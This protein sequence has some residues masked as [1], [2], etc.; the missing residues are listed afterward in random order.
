[1]KGFRTS[2]EFD[3]VQLL[4]SVAGAVEDCA[5]TVGDAHARGQ[6]VIFRMVS[7]GPSPAFFF[8]AIFPD[9][10]RFLDADISLRRHPR[11]ARDARDQ[12]TK[13]KEAPFTEIRHRMFPNTRPSR[14][15]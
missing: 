9:K 4:F 1:M 10:H 3:V 11:E 14:K 13:Q 5:D 8:R 2:E 6:R 7:S 12:G 15:T